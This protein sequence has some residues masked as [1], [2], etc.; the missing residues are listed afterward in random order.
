MHRNPHVLQRLGVQLGVTV[1]SVTSLVFGFTVWTE[2]QQGRESLTRELTLRLLSKS[3]SLALAAAAPLLTHDPEL[4][5][6]P[7]VTRA[8]AET[9]EL[10]DLVVLDSRRRVQGTAD[11]Q[12]VGTVLPP[13][14]ARQTLAISGVHDEGV[15]LEGKDLIVE[16][17]VRHL[18]QTVGWLVMRASR[19]E[20]DAT[21]RA[22][23]RRLVIVGGAGTLIAIVAVGLM[24]NLFLRPLGELRRGVQRIGAGDLSTRVRV[25][26]HDELGM[27]TDL[28]NSMAAGLETAQAE[29]IEKERLDQ[30]LAI[31]RQLQSLLL[32]SGVQPAHGYW[33]EAHY[34]PALEVSGDYY[35]VFGLDADHVAF[36]AAD[37]SGKG[38]PGL[39]LMAMFRTALRSLASPERDPAD[40]LVAAGH[41]LQDS[42]QRGR[43]ITCLYGILDV[44]RHDFAW[45]SAGHCP[46]LLFGAAGARPL[47]GSGKPIGLFPE[48]QL[49]MSLHPQHVRLEPGDGLLL[50]T[51]GLVEAMNR[52]GEPLGTQAVLQHLDAWCRAPQASLLASLVERVARHR[53]GQ[54]ESDD[55]TLVVLQRE[56]AA[57]PSR[58][59]AGA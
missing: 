18:E 53:A 17:P 7:L 16:C 20:I 22:A 12:S 42:M 19:A 8:L 24:V 4:G 14:P 1:A 36:A 50:Y 44:R 41:M 13:D 54:D 37:V 28:L 35:D 34:T 39:V 31:A 38:V 6:H 55:M 46:P 52:E 57:V 5:L 2:A 32:P 40:V 9:P 25:R 11:M 3:R 27:F 26:S 59:G 58:S 21:V 29:R 48:P 45:T 47:P 49:R 33:F 43:F 56:R 23:E 10:V 15:W 51:D 30:E